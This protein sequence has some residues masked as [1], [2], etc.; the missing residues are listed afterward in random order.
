MTKLDQNDLVEYQIFATL[1]RGLGGFGLILGGLFYLGVGLVF[2]LPA[3]MLL[4]GLF[5][6]L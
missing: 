5:G 2:L 6:I 1:A 4:L 3:V